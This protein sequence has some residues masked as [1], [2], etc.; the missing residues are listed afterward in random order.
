MGAAF[1]VNRLTF[2]RRPYKFLS[3][4]PELFFVEIVLRQV[5][6]KLDGGSLE[7]EG[8]SKKVKGKSENQS[9]Q[10][11]D[12]GC[13]MLVKARRCPVQHLTSNI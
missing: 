8:K 2:V 13:W 10:M 5:W 12:A 6:P 7:Q 1:A 4:C 9:E 11:S 3:T